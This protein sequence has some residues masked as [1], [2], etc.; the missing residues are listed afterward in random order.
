MFS[1]DYQ[2]GKKGGKKIREGVLKPPSVTTLENL[3]GNIDG[4]GKRAIGA[5]W[6]KTE[7]IGLSQCMKVFKGHGLCGAKSTEKCRLL[8]T[9]PLLTRLHFSQ[10]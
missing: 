6:K 2:T 10:N 9:N 4:I 8:R 3:S 1:L 5:V 7:D